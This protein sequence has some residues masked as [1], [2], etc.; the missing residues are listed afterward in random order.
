M[1]TPDLRGHAVR[2]CRLCRRA[3]ESAPFVRLPD[4]PAI[5]QQFPSADEL[6]R[7]RGALLEVVQCEGCGHVQ[8][9]SEPVWY[10]RDVIRAGAVSPAMRAYRAAQFAEFVAAHDLRGRRVLEVGCGAG[11]YLE[12]LAQTGVDAVGLEHGAASVAAC[13]AKGL[14]VHQGFLGSPAEPAPGGPY[15][16][17]LILNFLEH[18]PD[19]A[20]SLGAIRASIADH[21][22]GLVEV[23]NLDMILAEQMLGEFMTDHLHY[24]TRATLRTALELNG[25]EVVR[26]EPTWHDYILSATVRPR[27][28]VD[29][30]PF[31]DR[32]AALRADLDAFLARHPPRSV[33]IWG[34][35]HQALATI[36][37]HALRDRVAFV[38]DSA[39][40]K[41]GRFTPGTHL[42]VHAPERLREGEVRGVLVMGA[43]YS[44]EIASIL[45]RDYPAH[46]DV[47]I[48]RASGLERVP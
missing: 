27:P 29:A 47:A 20:G 23:P 36:A 1:T 39:P 3:L 26:C 37:L 31:L 8:V 16:G 25:F 28:R 45:R 40:F 9:T 13:A 6:A 48:L 21:A 5:A 30:A 17:F 41:Q 43:S 7:D 11:E 22:V 42:P 4:M 2:A 35:G 19:L 24:F 38:V 44:D 15:D 32:A 12:I 18:L 34:A 14:A 33:A 46:L 10:H